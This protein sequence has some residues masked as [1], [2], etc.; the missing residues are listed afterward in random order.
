MPKYR[1]WLV[2]T[3]STSVEV[4]AEDGDEAVEVAFEQDLPYLNITNEGIDMGDW[5]VESELFP[6]AKPENDYELIEE[7]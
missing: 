5:T 3:V 7:D 4:E 6:H 2:S 1:V